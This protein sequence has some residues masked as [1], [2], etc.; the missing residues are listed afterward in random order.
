MAMLN[1]NMPKILGV[2]FKRKMTFAVGIFY[3]ASCIAIVCAQ[4]VSTMFPDLYATYMAAAIALLVVRVCWCIFV[5]NHPQGEEVPAG[6]P[7]TKYL[8]IA[9]RS[10]N[11]W[12]I[13]ATYG[14]T[15]AA[16]TGLGTIF[17]TTMQV[18]RGYSM[19]LSGSLAVV[20]TIGSFFAC[21]VGPLWVQLS[22]SLWALLVVNA[23]LTA[24]SG[25]IIEA[26]TYQL[27]EIGA[28]YAG[29]AGGIVTTTG[30]IFSY[31]LPIAVTAVIGENFM[32]LMIAYA[33]VFG[34]SAPTIALLPETGAKAQAAAQDK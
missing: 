3:V 23:F 31:A 14:L 28:K 12:L 27:P 18:A 13:A 29:S 11:V 15:L 33:V 4:S 34:L 21:I 17:P 5:K 7:V 30:M 26:M 2:R 1:T 24:C 25:P 9:A 19:E 32:V 16:T 10:K 8:R 22:P 20:G 6:E